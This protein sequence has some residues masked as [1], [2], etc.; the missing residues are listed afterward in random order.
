MEAGQR[1]AV[2]AGADDGDVVHVTYGISDGR[3]QRASATV[4]VIAKDDANLAP[5]A[6]DDLVTDVPAGATTVDV[7]VLANDDDLDGPRADLEIEALDAGNGPASTVTPARLLT[8]G[9]TDAP[10]MVAYRITDKEGGT[11]TAFVRVPAAGNQPPVRKKD[12]PS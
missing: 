9:L 7:D 1:V 10:R 2:K 11:A 4:T 6:R 5:V 8:V 12:A 3:G